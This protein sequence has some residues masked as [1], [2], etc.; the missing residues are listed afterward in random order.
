MSLP[1]QICCWIPEYAN[2]ELI[3]TQYV[4]MSM[5]RNIMMT[6]VGNTEIRGPKKF[7]SGFPAVPSAAKCEPVNKSPSTCWITKDE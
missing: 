6:C 3:I 2:N 7:F 1:P 4:V 5:L